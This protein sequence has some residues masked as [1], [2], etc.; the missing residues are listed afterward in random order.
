[1]LNHFFVHH[2]FRPST[3]SIPPS[4]LHTHAHTHTHTRT[5][6]YRYRVAACDRTLVWV[7]LRVARCG[8]EF[9]THA[10]GTS[11]FPQDTAGHGGGAALVL[12]LFHTS[13]RLTHLTLSEC[14]R[15]R[16]RWVLEGRGLLQIVARGHYLLQF[17]CNNPA[18]LEKHTLVGDNEGK[19]EPPN[20]SKK[21][22]RRIRHPDFYILTGMCS[23]HCVGQYILPHVRF[24][25]LSSLR[26]RVRSS[27]E[28]G[29]S[30]NS[31]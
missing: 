1:M 31:C 23:Q 30:W 22:Q 10:L 5:H 15:R 9:S 29:V 21:S 20:T 26:M 3:R 16:A 14:L 19:G 8:L 25:A 6:T 7:A 27:Q 4:L 17:Q 13:A 24:P 28:V 12:A 2:F 11:C 18:S